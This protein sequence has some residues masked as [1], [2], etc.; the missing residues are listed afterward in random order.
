MS[1]LPV[2]SGDGRDALIEFHASGEGG[3]QG[4]SPA[5]LALA[6][7]ALLNDG[8]ET[9]SA[10]LARLGATLVPGARALVE[11]Y[12][13]S[14]LCERD[15]AAAPFLGRL[16]ELVSRL[17]QHLALD[18]SHA[19]GGTSP[20]VLSGEL[21]P[22]GALV[23]TGTLS[24]LLPEHRGARRLT[25]E[26]R[27]RLEAARELLT[28]YLEQGTVGPTLVMLHSGAWPEGLSLPGVEVIQATDGFAQAVEMFD[29]RVAPLTRLLRAIRAVRLELEGAFEPGRHDRALARFDWRSA[30][31]DELPLLPRISVLEHADDVAAG[32]L[33]GLSVLLRSGRPVHALLVDR[34]LPSV[35]AT[36]EARLEIGYLA[37]AHRTAFVLQ[38]TLARPAQLVSA[39]SRMVGS[40]HAALAVVAAPSAG[41]GLPPALELAA[42]HEARATPC[43][44]FDPQAGDTWAACLQLDGNPQTERSWP[45]HAARHVDEQGAES[46]LDEEFTPAHAVVSDPAGMQ[47]VRQV[48]RPRW[49]DSQLEVATYLELDDAGRRGKLPYV[50][51]LDDE[52]RLVRGVITRA[53]AAVCRD[54]LA[55]WRILREL[56]GIDNEHASRIERQV[57][58]ETTSRNEESLEQ[59][60]TQ[61]E[62]QLEQLR[63]EAGQEAIGRLVTALLDFD[64]V[65]IS[66]LAAA[67]TVEVPAP[68]TPAPTASPS[69]AT[70]EPAGAVPDRPYIDT[71]LCT[72]CNEC[73]NL[74]SR[75]FRYNGD[76]QAYI[77]DPAAGTFAELVK[78]A[79]KCPAR[80]IHPGTPRNGDPS[81]TDKMLRR[82]ARFN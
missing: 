3:V 67:A 32:G 56:A 46:A 81:A 38:S 31:Q 1:D 25:D 76:K 16:R 5:R 8:A 64:G 18:A 78:A 52:R 70:E 37:A 68:S 19:P 77:A 45:V 47:H 26:R 63:Q 74:N 57:R 80:C 27:Q 13:S 72:T 7:S 20:E 60:V 24:G 51:L 50:W 6:D 48:P 71:P 55:T 53:L 39:L 22:A 41:C 65:A 62:Q 10:E 58:E 14:V 66:D 29:E 42:A 69:P 43:F 54:R 21:G 35:E 61:H 34:A 36:A 75:M 4:Q 15:A 59:L 23:D 33:D 30:T 17:T 12:A 40:P 82:A 2:I 73:T 79:E 9:L 28:G 44:C 49:D 11:L